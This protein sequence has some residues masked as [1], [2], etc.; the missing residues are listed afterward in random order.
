LRPGQ[1]AVFSVVRGTQRRT[2]AVELVSRAA[3]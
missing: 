2:I 1:S 3:R